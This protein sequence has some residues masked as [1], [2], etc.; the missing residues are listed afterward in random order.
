MQTDLSDE[1]M[2]IMSIMSGKC[3]KIMYAFVF[4]S[5]ACL[6]THAWMLWIEG[7]VMGSP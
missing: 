7:Y 3:R 6:L 2:S 5:G 1:Y 4:R